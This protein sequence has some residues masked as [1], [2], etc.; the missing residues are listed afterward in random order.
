MTEILILVAAIV[1]LVTLERLP[2]V[3]RTAL[4]VARPGSGADVALGLVSHVAIGFA[5]ALVVQLALESLGGAGWPRP[6]AQLPAAAAVAIAIVLVDLGNYV[7]HRI[8]HRF[9]VL[10]HLH[11][12]HHSSPELDWLA[13]YRAHPLEMLF[14]RFAAPALLVLGGLPAHL[15]ALVGAIYQVWIMFN[16]SNLGLDLRRLEWLLVTPRLHRAH[17]APSTTQRNY[18]TL[19]TLWDRLFAT[20]A[21][22]PDPAEPTGVPGEVDTY[23]Q[24][25]GG[26]LAEPLRRISRAA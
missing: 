22:D 24:S 20:A 2:R 21:P 16:H 9:D 26:L 14:R 23:P 17:H 7:A 1:V 19:L 5:G 3:R 12:V 13:S 15:A 6:L 8:L 18:G 10:W 4:R 25:L 11:A